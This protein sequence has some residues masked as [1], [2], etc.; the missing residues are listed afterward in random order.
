MEQINKI[1]RKSAKEL[2]VDFDYLVEDLGE[3]SYNEPRR[4]SSYYA[5]GIVE[6]SE[7]IAPLASR[8]L[9]GFWETNEYTGDYDDGYD[10]EDID[11]LIR[12]KKQSKIV[13]TFEWVAC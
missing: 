10:G 13:E 4:G 5:K 11:E 8:E 7:K 12:V 9:D 3:Y 2:G 1:T 6:I